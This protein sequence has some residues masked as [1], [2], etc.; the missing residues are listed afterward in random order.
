M[1]IK[2][3]NKT[4]EVSK[5]VLESNPEEINIEF[6][7]T[8]RTQDEESVFIENHKKDARKE[9]LEIAVKQ[10]RDEFGFEGRSIDKL[11]EAVQKK[12]L[13]DA[14]I[15][16]AEQLK[17]IQATLQ[18]KETALQ[19]ALTKVSEKENE[20]K[21]FKN[22]TKLDQYLDG[23]IP[24]NTILPKEDIKL[25]LKTKMKFDIDENGSV[26]ALDNQGNVIKD[27]TTAN[28]KEAKEV[29]ESFFKDNQT[30]LKPIEGGS[31]A[32]DSG[33]A[34]K[35]KSIDK[36]IEEMN[37]KG[38]KLNSQEFNDTLKKEVEAGLVEVD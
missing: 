30:Y 29:V 23:V 33:S 9:G 5:E 10:Y 21:S 7:G 11:I 8:L 16:P 27:P 28:P 18:E 31:G 25:I 2:I 34:G 12:T 26:L 3:G 6:D 38:V 15:E 37:S 17:K 13:E 35:K 36:F 1:K 32:G 22:Q 14:K 19:N 24:Q 20:F 4:F